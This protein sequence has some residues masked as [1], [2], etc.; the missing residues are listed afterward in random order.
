M[1]NSLSLSR[2]RGTDVVKPLVARQEQLFAPAFWYLIGSSGEKRYE[3]QAG[4]ASAARK[5]TLAS[6]WRRFAALEKFEGRPKPK[7]S[8]ETRPWEPRWDAFLVAE[9]RA[10]RA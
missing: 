3:T 5:A 2:R 6:A 1:K 4:A 9:R 7:K 10:G 8:D